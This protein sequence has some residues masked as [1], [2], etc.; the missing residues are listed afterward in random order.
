MNRERTKLTLWVAAPAPLLPNVY[1][2]CVKFIVESDA[3]GQLAF[4]QRADAFIIGPAVAHE[5]V[6]PENP[7]RVSID[8]EYGMFPSIEKDRISSFPADPPNAQ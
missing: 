5:A 3:A 1:E 4:E 2:Q 6:P 7:V 8:Y